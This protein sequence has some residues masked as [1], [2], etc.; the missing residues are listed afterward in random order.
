MASKVALP[1]IALFQ[2]PEGK[3]LYNQ[4]IHSDRYRASPVFADWQKKRFI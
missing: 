4:R 3:E 2:S 1:N